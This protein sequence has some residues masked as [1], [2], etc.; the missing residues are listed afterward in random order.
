MKTTS[1]AIVIPAYKSRYLRATLHSLAKQ[2]CQD[3][4]LYI[5]D[6]ASPKP[7]EAIVREFSGDWPIHYV[8]FE[9]NLGRTALVRQWDRCIRLGNEPWVW[10]FS[11]DDT[12]DPEC[13]EK[14]YQELKVTDG[15]HDLYRF[16]TITINGDGVKLSENQPNPQ[17][18]SGADFLV[19]RLRGK[20]TCS[21]QEI[22]FSRAAWELAGGF[23]DFPLGWASDDAFIATLGARKGIHIIPGPRVSW[24]LSGQNIS[25]DN[26]GNLAILKIQACREFI[27][28]A[29]A[30]LQRNPS[31]DRHLV[32]GELAALFEDWFFLQMIYTRRLANFKTCLEVDKLASSSW[33]RQ[34]GYGFLKTLKFNTR[35]FRDRIFES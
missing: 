22:I 4:T 23:P 27:E 3:F 25:S 12:A 19:A 32:N 35:L 10:L 20:R 18:E 17:N 1:L 14:F 9:K 28:W 15:R 33:H 30:F 6:D 8:R 31:S 24:R 13:V 26:S 29:T 16:N 11:D 2:T 21:A 7:I 5:G 34:R